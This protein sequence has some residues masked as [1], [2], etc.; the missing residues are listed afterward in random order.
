MGIQLKK[1]ADSNVQR[2]KERLVP[3]C[4]RQVP[5]INYFETFSPVVN[6]V[7]IILFM[8][9]LVISCGWV[10]RHVDIKCAYLYANL[11]EEVFMEIPQ[12]TKY[13]NRNS[14]VMLLNKALYGL[15]QTGRL[16]YLELD[17]SH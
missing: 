2:F 17:N 6:Y 11:K 1:D 7:L 10:H 4:F 9:L 14:L 3:Q 8:I 16:W 12:G 5:G 13:N 15:L